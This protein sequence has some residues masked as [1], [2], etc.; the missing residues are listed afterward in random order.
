VAKKT[1]P[2][3]AKE[4]HL[5]R[6]ALQTLVRIQQAD[7]RRAAKFEREARREQREKAQELRSVDKIKARQ[8]TADWVPPCESDRGLETGPW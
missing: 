1:E 5:I 8:R 4:L 7:L 3:I 2:S 6:K